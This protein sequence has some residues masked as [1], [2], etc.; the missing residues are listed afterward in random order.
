MT[1]ILLRLKVDPETAAAALLHDAVEDTPVTTEDIVENFG[2]RVQMLVD[3]V[4]KLGKLSTDTSEQSAQAR[5]YDEQ[6]ENLRKMFLAMAEDI[7]VVLIKLADRLHNMRT[8]ELSSRKTGHQG[9]QTHGD[10]CSAGEPARYLADK[11]RARRFVF[12]VSAT[13][14]IRNDPAQLE[15]KGR[16]QEEYVERVIDLLDAE[17]KEQDFP[18]RLNGRKKHLY[19]IYRKMEQKQRGLDEIYDVLGIRVIVEKTADCYGAVGVV[20]TMW[21]PIPGE[22]DD[23]IATPKASQYR[24]LHTAV[25]G[26]GGYPLEIQIRTQEMH[27]D[28]EYGVA[29][30]WR[31]K[32]GRKSDPKLEEK[33]AWLR[34]LM[35][36]R[37]EISDAE[38]FVEA[39]KSEYF[40]EQIYV[41]TPKGDVIELP[42][43][44]DP[45]RFCLPDS[46]R[47]GAP[48]DW[49][50]SQRPTGAADLQTQD[51][52][53]GRDR[54]EQKQSRSKPR[55]AAG[56]TGL[57][58]DPGSAG[59]DPPMVPA[60][61]AGGKRPAGKRDA[62]KGNEA[63]RSRDE[64]RRSAGTVSSLYE[65]RRFPGG[66]RLWSGVRPKELQ[67]NL[68]STRPRNRLA[69]R[70]VSRNRLLPR[71]W[72]LAERAIC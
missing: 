28:A 60:S 20:H 2:E 51:G 16:N 8:L 53:C 52:R 44:I 61:G 22:F 19:S 35:E 47:G 58:Q 29:A 7:G 1:S 6:S 65:T 43:G 3:G 39:L 62:R 18:G 4:T 10:L 32:E 63:S 49:R 59:K 24:S 66:D 31:Y 33:V 45:G 57:C 23:Y 9:R 25:I 11:G 21:H 26:P 67:R 70:Q 55:L 5:D 68:A 42:A 69:V 13:N 27:D 72:S 50:Q 30:H 34:Q 41:F 46:H 64:T 36:W 40:H 14:G 56:R 54:N 38:D 71:A 37:T 15:V 48:H 12:R 17:L